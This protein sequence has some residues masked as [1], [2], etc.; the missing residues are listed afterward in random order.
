MEKNS[1]MALGDKYLKT[2][3]RWAFLPPLGDRGACQKLLEV[4]ELPRDHH[5]GRLACATECLKNDTV[6]FCFL[7]VIDTYCDPVLELF[8]P[9]VERKWK[10]ANLS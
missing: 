5:I 3:I 6:S 8:Y 9:Q 4:L 2:I 1:S 7:L 10:Y